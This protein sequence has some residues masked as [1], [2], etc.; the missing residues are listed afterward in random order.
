MS[1][2][3]AASFLVLLL[4]ATIVYGVD[5]T[6]GENAG[7]SLTAGDYAAWAATQTFTVGDNLVFNYDS[8]HGVDVVNEDDYKSCSSSNPINSFKGGRT[9]LMLSS[10]GRVYIICPTA[11][12]CSAGMKLAIT[13]VAAASNTPGG[14]SP[15]TTTPAGP[16]PPPRESDN[17]PI[18]NTSV[19][20]GPP[21]P[22]VMYF[23]GA[24]SKFGSITYLMG[25]L[26]ASAV[27]F[28]FM[29]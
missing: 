1:T 27:I 29:G 22:V 18:T 19:P 24:V 2:V 5:H 12:H 25:S 11:G 17:T 6:V 4:T 8:S 10:P 20:P 7:W 3:L 21:L 23:S 26:F 9:E 16:P 14:G 15:S 28:A 13:V